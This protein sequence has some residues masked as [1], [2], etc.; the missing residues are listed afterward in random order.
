MQWLLKDKFES[1]RYASHITVPTRLIA[2]E[3][4]EVIP[5]SSSQRLYGHFAKGVASMRVIKG[6][7]HNSISDSP[8]YFKALGDGL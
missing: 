6:T 5:G 4:D 1:W 8:E 2:A 7:G 3:H